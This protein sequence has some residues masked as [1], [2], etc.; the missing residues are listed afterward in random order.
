MCTIFVTK[1][2]TKVHLIHVSSLPTGPG[3]ISSSE[4]MVDVVAQG[5]GAD[6]RESAGS[7]CGAGALGINACMMIEYL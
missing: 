4:R 3:V 6:E 2:N 7:R 1:L 5:K